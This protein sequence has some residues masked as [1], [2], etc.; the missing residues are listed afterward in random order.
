MCFWLRMPLILKSSHRCFLLF[1]Y[2]GNLSNFSEYFSEH[3]L[4]S[5][6]IFYLLLSELL[7]QMY[8]LLFCGFS[9]YVLWRTTNHYFSVWKWLKL[10][11]VFSLESWNYLW[12]RSIST[13]WNLLEMQ[14]SGLTLNLLNLRIEL[15]NLCL[16][17]SSWL[18]LKL[19]NHCFR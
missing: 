16:N 3:M 19:D 7:N 10:H 4:G 17:I 18:I 8:L 1:I 9:V 13:I 15:N 14:I 2:K 6:K 11:F 12:P 5:I